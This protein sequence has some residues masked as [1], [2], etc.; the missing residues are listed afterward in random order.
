LVPHLEAI[1]ESPANREGVRRHALA[2]IDHAK[3]RL[4]NG[5]IERGIVGLVHLEQWAQ[6]K[7]FEHIPSLKNSRPS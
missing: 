6:V 2:E 4:W 5:R 7:C 1:H 3:W